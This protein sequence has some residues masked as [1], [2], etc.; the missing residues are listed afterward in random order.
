MLSAEAYTKHGLN[1]HAVVFDEL[2]A[3]PNRQLYDV[4]THGSGD[5]RNSLSI[6]HYHSGQ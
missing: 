1:V 4:M 5:A 3:Q 2:H 6:S